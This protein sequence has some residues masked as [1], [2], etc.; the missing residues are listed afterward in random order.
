MLFRSI[1]SGKKIRRYLLISAGAA[2]TNNNI[3]KMA[4]TILERKPILPLALLIG[5]FYKHQEEL[6]LFREKNPDVKVFEGVDLNEVFSQTK[7]GI[8]YFGVT[9]FEMIFSN[10]ACGVFATNREQLS[11]IKHLKNSSIFYDLGIIDHKKFEEKI[12]KFLNDKN[13]R[14]K[15]L[16]KIGEAGKLNGDYEVA[17]KIQD[18]LLKI[19]RKSNK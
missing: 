17:K 6:K 14:R 16:D 5:P 13:I 2:D 4:Q 1:K 8:C 18:E 9:M 12:D 19:K 15:I 3:L 7:I 10:I 11:G